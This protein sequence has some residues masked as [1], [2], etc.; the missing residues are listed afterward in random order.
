MSGAPPGLVPLGANV[1]GEVM[2]HIVI[3]ASPGSRV[4][5]PSGAGDPTPHIV[6]IS[7]SK[8][9]VDHDAEAAT[10]TG[11]HTRWHPH[12]GGSGHPIRTLRR[13]ANWCDDGPALR[14]SAAREA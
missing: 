5:E 13:A 11:P 3:P 9:S 1:F 7:T 2:R 12:H 4:L 14:P 6:I 8:Y 10:V